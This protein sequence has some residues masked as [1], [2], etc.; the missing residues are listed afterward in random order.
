MNWYIKN[1]EGE[2]IGVSTTGRDG[3]DIDLLTDSKK[4]KVIIPEGTYFT[5]F[6]YIYNKHSSLLEGIKKLPFRVINKHLWLYKSLG[7]VEIEIVGPTSL[8]EQVDLISIF[9]NYG[10]KI[11]IFDGALDRKSISL[12]EKITD[13]VL[14]IGASAG[15]INEIKNQAQ[16]IKS[17]TKF[18]KI[19]FENI[20]HTYANQNLLRKTIGS[21]IT[22]FLDDKIIETDLNSIYSNE[23]LIIDIL[24]KNPEWIYFSGA[25]TDLSWKKLKN[26]MLD[27][28]GKI[29]FQHP[30]NINIGLN[31][32]VTLADSQK[33]FVKNH[34]PITAVAVNSYS[35]R[36]EHID[37]EIL[38]NEI[39]EIFTDLPVLDVRESI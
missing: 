39:M 27:Y 32:I 24:S 15:S 13:I 10:C 3:E 29:I 7:S 2:N 21:T 25:M 18:E 28:K 36:N 12:S 33:I 8:K 37:A 35:P 26:N 14:V 20:F 9:E 19:C 11:I 23:S 16:I 6:D 5:S 38:R 1:L 31:D 17:F 22:Y 34:F 4:P 30:L